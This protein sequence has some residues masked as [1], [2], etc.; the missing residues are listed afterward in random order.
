M[1]NFFAKTNFLSFAIVTLLI[2]LEYLLPAQSEEVVVKKG[3]VKIEK[4]QSIFEF[5]EHVNFPFAVRFPD[6]TIY[7]NFS[8]GQ[9]V[10]NERGRNVMSPDN[11]RTWKET[12]FCP[13]SRAMCSLGDGLLIHVG[14]WRAKALRGRVYPVSV[15]VLNSSGKTIKHMK[16]EVGLPWELE[17][18][19]CLHRSLV[20]TTEGKLVASAYGLVKGE[21]L[22]RSY[23]IVSS[24]E[25]RS[26]KLLS[27]IAYDPRI[28]NNGYS[29]PVLE[30]LVNGDLLCLMRTGS[31]SRRDHPLMQSRSTDGGRTWDVPH[32]IAQYGVDPDLKL[33]SSGIL[34]A[35]SG[36]PGV[37]LMV[38]FDGNGKEWDKIISIYKGIG[39][40][41]TS[42]LE[43]EP[44]LIVVLY[45]KSGF[46]QTKG[47]MLNR[48]MATYI[49]L[50][51]KP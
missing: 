13:A 24:D 15:R 10:V 2:A 7:V 17:R 35:T 37:F 33:L 36:R 38:D 30:R 14:G 27:T 48:L 46:C 42:V 18:G 34:V 23:C 28:G 29:E 20:R 8:I 4:T 44:D 25:G 40:S 19:L 5:G 31:S 16:S 6:G 50:E 51:K 41:Y 12:R 22:S 45:T 26:W 49:R 1:T 32:E 11:G 21:S 3:S 47:P 43:L 9:H 39:C